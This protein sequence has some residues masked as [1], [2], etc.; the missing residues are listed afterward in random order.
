MYRDLDPSGTFCGSQLVYFGVEGLGVGD[1]SGFAL[2]ELETCVGATEIGVLH[3]HTF[4][5]SCYC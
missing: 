1:E 3:S 2:Q 5:R 4:L